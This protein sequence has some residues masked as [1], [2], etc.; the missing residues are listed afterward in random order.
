MMQKVTARVIELGDRK[1]L[2]SLE[3]LPYIVSDVLNSAQEEQSIQIMNYSLSLTYG[4]RPMASVKMSINGQVYEQ[5]A[6]GDG[7]FNA[8]SK[9]MWKIYK[10]LN[11]PTPELP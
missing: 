5:S 6:S 9:A 2:V 8:V 1:E 7:Q 4:L 10:S 3:E 11:K